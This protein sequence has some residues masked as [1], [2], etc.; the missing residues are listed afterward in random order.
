MGPVLLERD[1]EL[2]RLRTC[3]AEATAGT[4]SA[5][6]LS[7]EAGVGKTS[8]VRAFS[9]EV[10]GT[11]RMLAGA[12]DDLLSPRTF[13]PLRDAVRGGPLGEALT[14]G[15]R[16]A[17]LS[18]IEAELARPTT[19]LLVEDVHWADDATLDVLRFLARRIA[20]LPALLVLTYRDDELGRGHPLHRVLGALG[21]ERVHRL[22]LAPLSRAA[23]ARLAGGTTATSARLYALTAGNPF[24]VTEALAAGFD[25][26][27]STVV[28]A[29]LARVRMLDRPVQSALEQLAVVPSRVEVPL[30]RA[31]LGDITLLADAEHIGMLEVRPDAVA[32]RHELARRAVEGTLPR[33]VQ[34]ELNARVLAALRDRDGVDPARIVH[35]AVAAGDDV[36]VVAHAPEAARRACAAGAQDQGAMLYRAA[37]ARRELLARHEEAALCEA[38]AWAE[39]HANHRHEALSA[40]ERAVRLRERLDDRSALGRALATLA[41]QQWT[42]M[43]T[44]DAVASASRAVDLLRPAGDSAALQFALVYLGVV[45]VNVDRERESLAALDEALAMGERLG[46][47]PL[48]TQTLIYRGRA[49]W[50]LGDPSGP[51]ELRRALAQASAAEEHGRVALGY[52][53]HVGLLWRYGRYGEIDAVLE[54][55]AAYCR[56][57]EFATSER[58]WDAYRHRLA[59]LRGDWAGGEAGLRALL[60]DADNHGMLARH[61]LPGLA[62]IAVRR[63]APDAR[64]LL[65]AAWENAEQAKSLQAL[66]PTAAVAAELGWLTGD[67]SLGRDALALLPRT[68]QQGRER[69]RAELLRWLRRLG[70]PAETFDGCPE[71]FAADLRGDWR[72]AAT[73]WERVGD[74]YERA[75]Q[76]L[77]SGEIEPMLEALAVFDGLGAAPAALLTRRRLRELDVRQVPRGPQA[78][79][80]ANPAG[81]TGRQLEILGLVADGLTNAEIAARLVLSVRTVDHHVSSVLQ[82]LN[83][84]TRRAAA[85]LAARLAAE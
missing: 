2:S 36:A 26:V 70:R 23:V 65:A 39:F 38:D 74:P 31:L 55:G 50:Q 15:D 16:D 59:A 37:L 68:A 18:G 34:I 69:D 19:V 73:A 58:A 40:A 21:G 84:P 30:A 25:G 79:T 53:N 76:L 3:L 43:R 35:H 5:V 83:V 60:D 7:G 32:F 49:L 20:D 47:D 42:N 78:T 29:V 1:Q 80:R 54:A 14:R 63:G 85:E 22:R 33:S 8:V 41:L 12:C 28:D 57:R 17:V 82:K 51:D 45:L 66:V 81:L 61:A 10:A 62:R 44:D 46:A 64:E 6:L 11:V 72:T 56:N 24:F 52:V 48:R 9:R 13:G 75:V 67:P 27:P 4:G 71:E 77:D